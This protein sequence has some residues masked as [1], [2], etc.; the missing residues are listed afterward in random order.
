MNRNLFKTQPT[1]RTVPNE[2]GGKSYALKDKEAIAQ[3]AVTNCFNSTYYA[4]EKQLLEKTKEIADRVDSKFLAKVAVYAAL[5]GK[6]KDMPAFLLAIL[7]TRGEHELLAKVFPKVIHNFK[8]LSNF[9]QIVRSGQLG[10]KSFGT[11]TKQL[12]KD[13]FAR[14]NEFGLFM[15]S[16][17]ISD[18]SL[19]DVILM[20]HPKAVTEEQ[21]NMFKYILGLDYSQDIL[22]K[23][24]QDFENFKKDTSK[25]LP[26]VDFRLLS[27]IKLSQK[28]WLSLAANMSWNQLRMNLNTLYRNGVFN[29]KETTKIVADKLRNPEK[30]SSMPYQLLTTY[31]NTSDV[32]V[33]VSNALQDALEISVSNI[34]KIDRVAVCVDVSG[35]MSSPV[36]GHNGSATTKTSCLDV[37]ALVGAC[38]G[39]TSD[40]CKIIPFDTSAHEF[41]F[42]PKDSV[43]TNATALRRFYGG[44][45]DCSC[46]MRKLNNEGIEYDVVVFVS[47]NM[48]WAD[49]YHGRGTGLESEW[50]KYA[51]KFK[52]SK[53][54]LID[55][56]PYASTQV[57][58]SGRVL[59]V[60]GFSNSVF[61][62]IDAFVK[63]PANS[64]VSTIE[65]TEL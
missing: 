45:T 48:S 32:P 46:A 49:F 47:D 40:N 62:V 20:A 5:N 57:E 63:N 30:V 17:G 12:I 4:D 61:D 9:V 7:H 37:A 34:P 53:L 56:Q 2:A 42:N 29:D 8:M 28:Q 19:K 41:K 16:Y 39:R 50:K 10:R 6:M 33:Q 58:N 23:P 22:P 25:P 18:P 36:T 51:S 27:N 13:W 64:F 21:N 52:N 24:V 35:S 31:Q 15:S 3:L 26:N 43:V 11:K 55:I 60:G 59:N 54:V 65:K 1:V 14:T 38:F 44:G